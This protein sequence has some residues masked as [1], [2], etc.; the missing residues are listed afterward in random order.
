[1]IFSFLMISCERENL[2]PESELV[3]E[4][5]PAEISLNF[6]SQE[7]NIVSRAERDSVDEYRVNNVYL[8]IF[9]SDGDVHERKFCTPGNGLSNVRGY[10]F[11]LMN[12]RQR[13]EG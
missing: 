3:E 7:N 10:Y 8:F 13:K 9:N 1:M 5:L 6:K 2:F 12:L 4:G 11:R